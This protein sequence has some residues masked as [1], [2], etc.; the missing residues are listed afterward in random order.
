ME[1]TYHCIRTAIIKSLIVNSISSLN[2]HKHMNSRYGIINMLILIQSKNHLTKLIGINYSKTENVNEQVAIL[3][4]IL[5]I[6]SNFVPNKMLTFDDRKSP[7]MT[8]YIK[9]KLHWK[10]CIYNQ[11]LNCSRNCADYDIL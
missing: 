6:F 10:N 5:N 3:N 8:E 2:I 4:I 7:W 9:S 11:Y 1:L